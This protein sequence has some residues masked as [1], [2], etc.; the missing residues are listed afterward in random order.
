MP[1]QNM[2]LFLKMPK[3]LIILLCLLL[4]PM[5]MDA[6]MVY[7]DAALGVNNLACG[8]IGSPCSTIQFAVDNIANNNDTVYLKSG[9]YSLPAI[10]PAGTPV[11]TLPEG[12]GYTFF[13]DTTGAGVIVDG[14]AIR[15]GFHYD[16]ITVCGTG[17]GPHDGI[18]DEMTWSFQNLTIQNCLAS[19]DNCG[20]T[21]NALGGGAMFILETSSEMYVRFENCHFE[22]NMAN[23]PT[24]PNNHG[25]SAAG[26]AI[27]F[28]GRVSGSITA[29]DSARLW[30]NNCSFL[31]NSCTQLANGGHG[32]AI[33]VG[34]SNSAEITNSTFCSNSVFGTNADQGDLQHDRNAGGAILFI[35][36][37]SLTPAHDYVIDNCTFV[38]N[39]A[40]TPNG[41]NFSFQSE[42][43]AVF[44][45]RGD[46]LAASTNSTLTIGNSSFYGNTIETGTEHIANNSGTLDTTSIGNNLFG[47]FFVLNLGPDTTIC[48]GSGFPLVAPVTGASYLWSNG[49]TSDS[50]YVDS[51]GIYWVEITLGGCTASDTIEILP[52][53]F[54][55]SLGPDTTL[56]TDNSL[57]LTLNYPGATYLWS[58][59]TTG[60]S[61]VITTPGTIWVQVTNGSCVFTDTLVMDWFPPSTLPL[62]DSAGLCQGT[63]ITLNAF[64]PGTTQY[65]WSTIATVDTTASIQV[66]SGGVYSVQAI[67]SNGC[68][69]YDTTTVFVTVPLTLDLGP[70]S[71]L[72]E[73]DV[74]ILNSGITEPASFLWQDNSTG[75]TYSASTSN[76]ITLEA[77]NSCGTVSD[78]VVLTFLQLPIA[79]LPADTVICEYTTVLLQTNGQDSVNYTWFDNSSQASQTIDS[80]GTYWLTASNQCGTETDSINL[81]FLP[82]II[83]DLGNDTNICSG[84][85]VELIATVPQI[86]SYLWS[87]NTTDTSIFVNTGSVYYVTV[88]IGMCSKTDSIVVAAD[89][90]CTPPQERCAVFVPNVITPNSDGFNDFFLV[91]SD[92]PFSKFRLVVYNRWGRKIYESE[93]PQAVWKGDN[94]K[95]HVEDGVYFWML[96]YQSAAL[97]TQEKKGTVTV[98]H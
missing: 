45:T 14:G 68:A 5:I 83:F 27:Y 23:D 29:A 98:M 39:S 7:V 76:T 12:K 32:G 30:V 52:G 36:N 77:T 66:S 38:S 25:R 71:T 88:T 47:Q 3:P 46:N 20:S 63:P 43:G 6:Q 69:V 11:V 22:N 51:I 21:T 94:S 37:T 74:Y 18:P 24:G 91:T 19:T 65:V 55:F 96:E 4:A 53:A 87:D 80:S 64:L 48:P 26:G 82:P 16:Y 44:M 31:D 17:N 73:S 79:S 67:D 58:D 56:C 15:R 50:I 81:L 9:T 84:D 35:D 61:F 93:N 8:T 85:S 40:L 33:L 75:S 34:F 57:P 86:A 28:S 90:N 2:Q 13:G 78:T 89:S 54:T 62:N 92:C 72:C 49:S 60:F 97:G 70:D 59:N 41:A 1:I 95:P 42:G 10:V